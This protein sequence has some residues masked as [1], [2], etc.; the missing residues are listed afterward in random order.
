MKESILFTK[1]LVTGFQ[2]SPAECRVYR[3]LNRVNVNWEAYIEM[4]AIAVIPEIEGLTSENR[5]VA[6]ILDDSPYYRN[7]SKKVELLS[8][9]YEHSEDRYYKGFSLLTLGW[10]D[11]QSFI[12]VGYQMVASGND[13]NL[14][15]GSHIVD[16]GRT[17][18]TKRRKA[19]RSDKLYLA[20]KMLSS[21]KGTALRA[22]H[23]LFD[24]WFASPSFIISV[25]QLGY[26]VIARVKNHNNFRYL[27]EGENRP[28]SEI[29]RRNLKRRG[30]SRYL[31]SVMVKIRHNDVPGLID[32][33]LVFIRDR[34]NR[35]N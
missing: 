9:C 16:D 10:T 31:L 20:L 24:S 21:A 3:F 23:V 32:A 17:I 13:K 30:R 8:R 5:M 35:K 4:L 25:R 34:T 29:F 22:K 14:L 6:W 12:P 15:E 18:A 28:I 27:Y 26:H 19:A 11:G 2:E 1:R 7:R 33:K